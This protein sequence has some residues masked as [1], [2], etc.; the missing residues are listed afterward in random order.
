MSGDYAG[1]LT[2]Y[3]SDAVGVIVTQ[4]VQFALDDPGNEEKYFYVQIWAMPPKSVTEQFS[5]AHYV[6]C[7]RTIA[8]WSELMDLADDTY[9]YREYNR[10]H[11]GGVT[12]EEWKAAVAE[13]KTLNAK[14]NYFAAEDAWAAESGVLR[15]KVVREWQ[16][17]EYERLKALG[18][19][20]YLKSD[21]GT[22]ELT[23]LLC[24][25]QLTNFDAPPEAFYVIEWVRDENGIV[26][27]Q[28]SSS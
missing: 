19:D 3:S 2:S 4:E 24:A 13:A 8:E 23:G 28:E 16:Q 11:G 6:Y 20:V 22:C 21:G 1:A 15:Q 14:E 18:Y 5:M 7:G 27:W 25:E 17:T 12:E 26:E 10:D 9:P